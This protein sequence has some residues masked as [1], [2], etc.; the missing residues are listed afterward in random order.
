MQVAWALPSA[1]VHI[2][3]GGLWLV[4]CHGYALEVKKRWLEVRIVLFMFCLCV[5][6]VLN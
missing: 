1:L 6:Y 2:P 5:L 3:S 4:A